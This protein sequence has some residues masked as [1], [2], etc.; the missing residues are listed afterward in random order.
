MPPQ[1]DAIPSGY[2]DLFTDGR[3]ELS[4]AIILLLLV[5]T[6]DVLIVATAM[7]TILEQLGEVELY[8]WIFSAYTLAS[9]ASLPVFSALTGRWGLLYMMTVAIVIFVL[10]SV[11]CALAPSMLTLVL[12]RGVQGIGAGGLFAIPYI[13][14]S[15][16]Y[17]ST[18]QPRALAL[19]SG[20]WGISSLGGPL[21][22]ALLLTAWGWPAIFWVNLP[23]CAVVLLLGF[24]GLRGTPAGDPQAAP[25]NLHSPL[26]L[27]LAAGLLLAAPTASA[28]LGWLVAGLG[29]AAAIAFV[30]VERRSAQPIVPAAAWRARGSLGA[31]LAVTALSA[32][33]FFAAETFL[34]LLLQSG[35]GR[36][37]VEAG[38]LIT[39]GSIA[40]T[41]G[42]IWAGRVVYPRLRVN[43]VGGLLAMLLGSL[44]LLLVAASLL[45]M[46]AAYPAWLLVGLGM[47]VQNQTCTLIVLD[48]ARGPQATSITASSQL[49]MS[50]GTSAGTAL[51]GIV[52]ALGFGA[53]FAPERAGG[54]LAGTQL[55]LLERGVSYALLL[56]AVMAVVTLVLTPRLP[57]EREIGEG[58]PDLA[59]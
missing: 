18:L 7:P 43:A 13:T 50:L 45:P 57:A 5:A 30:A 10:G 14:I 2:R 49:A 26:L 48:S 16:R 11:V 34:P 39:L 25:A 47:G 54:V 42:A 53:S 1:H 27:T 17:P 55:L 52:A 29:L 15:Q 59:A 31:S 12:G 35:R 33:S 8:S 4:L 9:I 28:S 56:A 19:T 40:W 24:I 38:A 37:P 41:A 51:A 32:V 46:P 22:G 6:L 20:V 44:L 58:Q 3:A 21:I 36:S 23:L